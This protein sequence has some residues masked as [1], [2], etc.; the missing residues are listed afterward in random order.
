MQPPYNAT[1]C[2]YCML[3]LYAATGTVPW[4]PSLR[5]FAHYLAP[6]YPPPNKCFLGGAGFAF[7]LGARFSCRMVQGPHLIPQ[8]PDPP[9][10]K[11]LH[12]AEI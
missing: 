12:R 9:T 10:Q 7:K 8:I 11:V 4:L 2:C 6:P 3:L 5:R 1:T